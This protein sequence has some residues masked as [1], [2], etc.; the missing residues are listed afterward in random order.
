MKISFI[1]TGRLGS[2]IAYTTALRG[3]GDEIVAV[4]L[5]EDLAK[6]QTSDMRHAV[7]F[8]I[9]VRIRQA[10]YEA[11]RDSDV[12]VVTAGKPRSPGMT[13]LDLLETNVA[14][15]RDI[16]GRVRDFA[17]EAVM[18][19]LTN[20]M[21]V[22]NYIATRE[23][24]FRRTRVIGSGGM[25]DTA[26]FRTALA[27][28]LGVHP[29]AVQA[30]VLGEHGDSQVP[31]WSRVE[32]DGDAVTL[33]EEDRQAI[34]GISRESAMSVIE[35]KKATEFGPANCTADMI[36]AIVEDRG[37][38]I[39]S[40]IAAKGEYGL[41]ELSIG[42]PVVL[43]EG[44]VKE[45]MEWDLAEDELADMRKSGEILRGGVEEALRVLEA[46]S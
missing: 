39:P 34:R 8:K 44:G 33:S 36:E 25:L 41:K 12:V 40:S 21:D 22:L 5:L 7:E 17:P 1:G 6:G 26:R 23:T 35:G 42:M 43:G 20:P 18:I 30:F 38:L 29:T 45:V 10:G 24:G 4:D 31:V 32:V 19:N 11:T 9:P 3:L 13:R 15:M 37:V 16:A 2:A 28:H 27:D 14:I 46:D